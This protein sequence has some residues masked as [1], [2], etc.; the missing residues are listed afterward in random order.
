MPLPPKC[1]RMCT[2]ACE[3]GGSWC[4]STWGYHFTGDHDVT[5]AS[6]PVKAFVPVRIRLVTPISGDAAARRLLPGTFVVTRLKDI[7]GDRPQSSKPEVRVHISLQDVKGKVVRSAECPN[8]QC[9]QQRGLEGGRFH[10]K[11]PRRSQRDEEEENSFQPDQPGATQIFHSYGILA[12]RCD[13]IN[14]I[15]RGGRGRDPGHTQFSI[16]IRPA[17]I[18]QFAGMVLR[19]GGSIA[20]RIRTLAENGR[21]PTT[22]RSSETSAR[23][24][25]EG[26]FARIAPARFSRSWRVV[27][28]SGLSIL[29]SERKKTHELHHSRR[30]RHRHFRQYHCCLC[31]I[32]R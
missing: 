25:P 3:A 29:K 28:C 1:K 12:R 20:V 11:Q 9:Q 17:A 5:A 32:G 31:Q 8:Y 30:N 27:S 7:A 16:W 15:A 26:G 2:P 18:Q 22:A 10:P 23:A 21:N 13:G 6:R 24:Q 14:P 4:E 19:M